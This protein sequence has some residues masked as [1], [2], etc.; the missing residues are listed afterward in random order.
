MFTF[1]VHPEGEEPFTVVAEW[2]D[3][4][5]WEKTSQGKRCFQDLQERLRAEDLNKLAWIAARRQ[6]LFNGSL[7]EFDKTVN[8][9]F[10]FDE[11]EP[12]P[13]QPAR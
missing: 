6:G 1:T 3:V 9:D 10:K 13:T 8:L 7:A 2:R 12:D 4:V 11:E 5:T